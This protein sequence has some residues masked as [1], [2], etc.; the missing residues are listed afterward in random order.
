MLP[1]R[2]KSFQY[3]GSISASTTGS[4]LAS[5]ALSNASKSKS[6]LSTSLFVLPSL[7]PKAEASAWAS[8]RPSLITRKVF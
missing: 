4:V 3:L 6:K 8:S 2:M 5:S 1:F 7:G